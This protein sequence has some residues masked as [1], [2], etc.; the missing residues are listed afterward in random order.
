MQNPMLVGVNDGVTDLDPEPYR[1]AEWNRAFCDHSR[2]RTSFDVLHHQDEATRILDKLVQPDNVLVFETSNRAGLR[3]QLPSGRRRVL[4]QRADQSL[5][6]HL[7]SSNNSFSSARNTWPMP[8]W[9]SGRMT[10]HDPY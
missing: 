7:T 4:I 3:Q 6:G 1:Q 10:R 9:P 5:E 8:P 2:A